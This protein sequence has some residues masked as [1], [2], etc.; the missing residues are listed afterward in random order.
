M[1]KNNKL[2]T[3]LLVLAVLSALYPV[4]FANKGNPEV[5]TSSYSGNIV[6]ATD[7]SIAKNPIDDVGQ[8]T[9]VS[10][11][12]SSPQEDVILQKSA[13][14]TTP[15][16]KVS[17]ENVTPEFF[18]DFLQGK[19]FNFNTQT[20]NSQGVHIGAG[21]SSSIYKIEQNGEYFIRKTPQS[22]VAA[23]ELD[24]EMQRSNFFLNR[25]IDFALES[26]IDPV[27]NTPKTKYRHGK[28]LGAGAIV[29]VLGIEADGSIIQEYADGMDMFDSPQSATS[30]WLSN[31]ISS[32]IDDNLK[33]VAD[34]SVKDHLMQ[35]ID[36][37]LQS[38]LVG[39][40]GNTQKKELTNKLAST[41]VSTLTTKLDDEA[42]NILSH[43]VDAMLKAELVDTVHNNLIKAQCSQPMDAET[44]ETILQSF[45]TS[46][47]SIIK[48]ELIPQIDFTTYDAHNLKEAVD[49]AI[50]IKLDG[51]ED[52]FVERKL[53]NTVKSLQVEAIRQINF[54]AIQIPLAGLLESVIRAVI[55][56]QTPS[57]SPLL[58]DEDKF[59]DIIQITHGNQIM[60]SVREKLIDASINQ[61]LERKLSDITTSPKWKS[62]VFNTVKM[63]LMESIDAEVES[64]LENLID[65]KS[66]RQLTNR[67]NEIIAQS[68]CDFF[69]ERGFPRNPQQ[70]IRALCS[71]LHALITLH[72]LGYAHCDIKEG[73]VILTKSGILKLIDLGALARIGT[74]ITTYSANGA[75]E[76]LYADKLQI[77]MIQEAS[78]A[79]DMYCLAGVIL[80]SLFGLQGLNASHFYFFPVPGC[81]SVPQDILN[82]PAHIHGM[83]ENPEIRV[84][85]SAA[86]T[87]FFSEIIDTLN[88]AMGRQVPDPQN[89]SQ[90]ITVGN[91]PP[92]VLKIIK[93]I[94]IGIT[95]LDPNQR[96]SAIEVLELL[97]ELALSDW[98]DTSRPEEERYR[99]DRHPKLPEIPEE[100]RF[101]DWDA[102]WLKEYPAKPLTQ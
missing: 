44:R 23:N 15:I 51:I 5:I 33:N 62:L 40:L 97:Q 47:S 61:L 32:A 79:Y 58:D 26:I 68:R 27:T 34:T 95:E 75:P 11:P 84:T 21:H 31:K 59:D 63:E 38:K 24:H 82:A 87:E 73:N 64:Y 69:E 39:S 85:N 91:Y 8:K 20:S 94:L 74:K 57:L 35:S 13:A 102:D 53:I 98:N 19:R 86:R 56:H 83:I 36:T 88:N 54:D 71:L 89:P 80:S 50:K 99:I 55:E 1:E 48:E 9:I 100:N 28:L 67:I 7:A 10:V 66:I 81:G 72:E 49:T 17:E 25:A 46:I 65:H 78:P 18:E 92:Y 101:I 77:P 14:P 45:D 41:M 76:F 42:K 43:S 93:K 30:D 22:T 90:T 6:K 2:G 4:V 37:I 3:K 12:E 52:S 96:P 70:A 16:S 29:Q 60:F